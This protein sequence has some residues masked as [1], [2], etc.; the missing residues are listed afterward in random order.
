M[1]LRFSS[2]IFIITKAIA[3]TLLHIQLIYGDVI[4]SE[5]RAHWLPQCEP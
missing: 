1:V 4:N 3:S 5:K 2:H